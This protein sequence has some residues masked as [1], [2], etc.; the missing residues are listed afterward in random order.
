MKLT[1]QKQKQAERDEAIAYLLKILRPG[2]EVATITRHTSRSGMMR[3]ISLSIVHDNRL[4]DITWHAAHAMGDT[5]AA[6]GGIK[7]PGCG[8]DMGFHLVYN[9]GRTLWPNGNGKP[10]T[11]SG[12]TLKQRWI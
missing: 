3:H 1:K 7:T 8:M 9:L 2:T 5:R 4:Q 10:D 11:D 12:Y 6:D